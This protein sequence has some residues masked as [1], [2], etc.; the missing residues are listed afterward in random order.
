MES[1]LKV[2]SFLWLRKRE[3]QK[4][5]KYVT[6]SQLYFDCMDRFI[7]TGATPIK[8]STLP[9]PKIKPPPFLDQQIKLSNFSALY[10]TYVGVGSVG[11][12]GSVTCCPLFSQL[13]CSWNLR[14]VKTNIL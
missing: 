1:V 9:L 2:L 14:P 3:G 4:T 5:I 6:H 8:N 10:T 11:S 13:I 7:A 12:V